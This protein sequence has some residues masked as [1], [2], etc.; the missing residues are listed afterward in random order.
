MHSTWKE[1]VIILYIRIRL[2]F[3]MISP[4]PSIYVKLRFISRGLSVKSNHIYKIG[5][6]FIQRQQK[7]QISGR[8]AS[9]RPQTKTTINLFHKKK[10]QKLLIDLNDIF[11]R[12]SCKKNVWLLV[13]HLPK[14]DLP[15]IC[16]RLCAVS[17]TRFDILIYCVQLR[18]LV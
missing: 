10:W 1:H 8:T 18:S 11:R 4:I 14:T 2:M 12:V 3:L 17:I 16:T 5:A 9:V 15:R 6:L 7:V 13:C